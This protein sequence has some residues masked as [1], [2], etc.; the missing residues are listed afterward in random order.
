MLQEDPKQYLMTMRVKVPYDV[1]LLFR[2]FLSSPSLSPYR[3]NDKTF[4]P[5]DESVAQV[6]GNAMLLTAHGLHPMPPTT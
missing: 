4:F 1:E 2:L 5:P 6:K 3:Q